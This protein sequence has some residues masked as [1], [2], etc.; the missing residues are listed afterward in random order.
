MKPKKHK[1]TATAKNIDAINRY[2]RNIADIWSIYSNEYEK[3]TAKVKDFDIRTN[4]NGVIQIKNTKENRKKHQKVRALKNTI[5]SKNI[6]KRKYNK[7][8]KGLSKKDIQ[9]I[10]SFEDDVSN[11]YKKLKELQE[12]YELDITSYLDRL[13]KGDTPS[14]IINDALLESEKQQMND[15]PGFEN[16]NTI[17]TDFGIVDADTGELLY[18]F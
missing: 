2:L 1:R 6:I 8:T 17:E 7:R 5:K 15:V 18:E 9:A 14:S 13:R 12:K 11:A 10:K 3:A 16:R 4:K